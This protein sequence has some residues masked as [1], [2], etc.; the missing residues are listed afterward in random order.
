VA[1]RTST[2]V[3]ARPA[4]WVS[5]HAHGLIVALTLIAA[6]S[7]MWGIELRSIWW[8]ES[9]SLYRAQRDVGYILSNRIDFPGIYTTDQHPPLYFLLLHGVTQIFGQSDLALR[10]PSVAF[11]TLLVPLT[12]AL[13]SAIHRRRLGVL[14][15]AF[16]ALSPFY[17]WYAQ[18][19]RMYTMVTALGVVAMVATL[20]VSATQRWGWWVVALAAGV[21]GMAT[22]YLFL[23]TLPV[24]G[25]LGLLLYR[26]RTDGS[27]RFDRLSD[28][29][30]QHKRVLLVLVLVALGALLAGLISQMLRLIPS[31]PA[32]RGYVPLWI[33]ARDV[34]NSF[35]LGLSVNLRDVLGLDALFGSVFLLGLVRLV[36][37]PV[38]LPS[39][40]SPVA[41][42]RAVGLTVTLGAILIPLL[43]M[44]AFSLF[45]PIY[46]NSRYA[47]VASPGFYLGVAL[48]IDGLLST[49]RWRTL[50]RVIGL[51]L[52]VICLGAMVWSD[53]RYHSDPRYKSKE[54]YR[55]IAEETAAGER[56]GDL[57]I[58]N[59][60]ESMTAFAHYF[61]GAM[62]VVGWPEG[63]W[64]RDDM[65][66]ALDSACVTYQRIWFVRARNEISD[67]DEQLLDLYNERGVRVL[68]K[69]YPS[70]GY[71]M[72]LRAMVPHVQ[73]G[74]ADAEPQSEPLGVY[75]QALRLESAAIRYP[76]AP[77]L[78]E[79]SEVGRCATPQEG[80]ALAGQR[81][82]VTVV[83]TPLQP[84]ERYKASLRLQRDGLTW[85]Q[86]D[87]LPLMNWPT[88]RWALGKATRFAVDLALPDGLPP[89]RYQLLLGIYAA[90]SGEA[91]PFSPLA[92][93]AAPESGMCLLG[94]IDVVPGSGGARASS[95][96]PQDPAQAWFEGGLTLLSHS[97]AKED[98][99]LGETVLLGLD[100]RVRRDLDSGYALVVNWENDAGIVWHSDTCSIT[101]TDYDTGRSLEGQRLL[102]RVRLSVPG[103]AESGIHTLHLLLVRPD[104]RMAWCLARRGPMI[105]HNVPVGMVTVTK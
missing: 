97:L 74:V 11:A 68:Q 21:A 83:A 10:L 87:A 26:P 16:A 47:I 2:K 95:E 18:E 6:A 3:G 75:G 71:F 77:S 73:V 19:A 69:S 8:D 51:V 15:S 4:D 98:V 96:S 88:E 58:V 56:C 39:A 105:G 5:G 9:L 54:A 32:L 43:T 93:D 48:G 34:L 101:G 100:W 14:A 35:S 79:P 72:S 55:E 31:L 17:L 20:R 85:A 89:G 13:G 67:P 65:A 53:V 27:D 70:H 103:D 102:G 12:Y 45:V 40:N 84:L 36:V 61:G 76:G 1:R 64:S 30:R 38:E 66:R 62:P 42:R 28:Y 49:A 44:W 90:E 63:G 46:T 29:W 7:Q 80:P 60:P 59:G 82:V 92:A 94:G 24:L 22:Q 50:S 52:L 25:L 37:R 57:V 99:R 23:L 41:R 86:R 104:G 78:A 91:L 33:M 81:T